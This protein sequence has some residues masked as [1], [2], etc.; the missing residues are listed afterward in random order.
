MREYVRYYHEDRI[1]D[2]I[3]KETARERLIERRETDD[4]TVAGMPRV[5][6]L[7]HRYAWRAAA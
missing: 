4:D 5:D 6:G 2:A 7:P 3:N 1:H